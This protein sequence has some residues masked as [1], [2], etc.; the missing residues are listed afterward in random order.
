VRSA[1]SFGPLAV[2]VVLFAVVCGG[3]A[4]Q[5]ADDPKALELAVKATF[6]FKFQPFV[7]WPAQAFASPTAPFTLCIVGDHPFGPLLDRVVEGQRT[8]DRDVVVRRMA[9]VSPDDH[10]QIL[11][12]GA[13]DPVTAKQ[14]QAPV[15]GAPVLTV[16][17]SIDDSGAKGMV[18]FVI[19]DNRVRF[20]IDDAAARRSGLV[21][22]SKL[23]SLAVSVRSGP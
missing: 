23:L 12:V 4:A 14:L 3:G 11:Y 15:A 9:T 18:N 13:A 7:T 6:L 20:E 10:C 16:T 8:L 1:G 19:A 22:S 2:M 17:D 21:I 5:A